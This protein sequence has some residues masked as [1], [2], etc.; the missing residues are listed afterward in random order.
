MD[1]IYKNG[2]LSLLTDM[3]QLTMAQ[4]YWKLGRQDDFSVFH[5]FFRKTPFGGSYVVAAGLETAMQYMS[6]WRFTESDCA[7]LREVPGPNG[8]PIFEPG[9]VDY[10]AK[11]TLDGVTVHAIPEGDLA[12]PQEPLLR[13]EGPLVQCQLLETPLLTIL[14]FQS[15][16]A[17]KSSRVCQAAQ[18]K[19]VM[20]F[21]LRRAHGPDGGMSMSR[22]AYIGGCSATSNTLAGKVL[23]IPVRGTHSH[24]WVMS[25]DDELEAFEQYAETAPD[26]S[27]LL[28]DTY[29]TLRG[30]ERA[31][32]V[33]HHLREKG[34]SL[35]GIRLDSGDLA[36]LSSKAREMLDGAGFTEAKIVVSDDLDEYKI[37]DMIRRGARIDVYGVGT[38]IA[39]CYDQPALGC[40]YKLAAVDRGS[41]LR[42]A[43]KTSGA[44][45]NKASIPGRLHVQRFRNV[46]GSV[47]RDVLYDEDLGVS[48]QGGEELLQKVWDKGQPCSP[49]PLADIQ[50]RAKA[51]VLGL[52]EQ[53]RA[54]KDGPKFPVVIE[55]K[56]AQ[57]RDTMREEA[58]R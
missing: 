26:N 32:Q 23:G 41:G 14:G 29:D 38:R 13:L 25:Y 43:M 30:I 28:V 10:L 42:F 19:G 4:S 11:T 15:L 2:A 33:G 17:T 46:E 5:L 24:A 6:A 47:V 3:Y 51:A 1:G 44:N 31:I 36:E 34:H 18:W 56:L 16:V 21:G 52:D 40:V 7:Y 53:Y 58:M 22:G 49:V 45:P 35:S 27:I 39:T 37:A 20:D 48:E 9:F 57:R 8:K 12:F 54:F 55:A 50:A